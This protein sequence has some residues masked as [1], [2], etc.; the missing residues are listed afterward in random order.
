MALGMLAAPIRGRDQLGLVIQ[1]EAPA[2]ASALF[3]V[4]HVLQYLL[5]ALLSDDDLLALHL[6][7]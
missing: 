5:R 4:L 2:A 6:V 1:N 7:L 3:K